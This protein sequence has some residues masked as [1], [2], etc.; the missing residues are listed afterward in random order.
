MMT[1]AQYNY[2]MGWCYEALHI[3]QLCCH[4]AREHVATGEGGFSI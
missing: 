2:D 4:T 1:E 3:A